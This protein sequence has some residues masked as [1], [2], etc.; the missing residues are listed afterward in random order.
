MNDFIP[1]LAIFKNRVNLISDEILAKLPSSRIQEAMSYSVMNGGKR[2]RPIL[3]YI[4]G[5]ALGVSPS[6][7]DLPAC[8]IEFMH[9]FSLIH[10]DLPSMDDDDLR[11]GKP[12]CHKAFSEAIAILAG[13]ALQTLSFEVLTS[14]NSQ[15]LPLQQ[16]RMVNI[17]AT[18]AGAA[19]MGYGQALDISNHQTLTTNQLDALYREKTGKMLE[20]C[21]HFAIIAAKCDNNHQ[22]SHLL[23]Y[24]KLI[25]LAF[26]IHD[27]IL[28]IEGKTSTLGK[29][30]GSDE[31][32][33]K[34]TYPKLIG[35]ESAKN[36][37]NLLIEEAI[38]SLKQA[39]LKNTLL[40]EFAYFVIG[41]NN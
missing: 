26:Q 3:V 10:D 7:L 19:G 29:P 2:L 18:A 40:E 37:V 23:T 14:P 11:R 32:F 6:L 35:L 24:A 38:G 22:S 27:D 12:S 5:K 36:K 41:R 1:H 39:S 9:C 13:D 4:T 15:L 17:L 31:K 28:D 8:A 16:S 25:G 34:I 21:V 30:T 33:N 20:A